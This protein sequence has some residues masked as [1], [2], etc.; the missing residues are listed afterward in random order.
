MVGPATSAGPGESRQSPCP[1]A[2]RRGNAAESSAELHQ[3]RGATCK[4]CHP[5]RGLGR[6]RCLRNKRWL[7]IRRECQCVLLDSCPTLL[8]ETSGENYSILMTGTRHQS[9]RKTPQAVLQSPTPLQQQ[10]I[11][12]LTL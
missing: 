7:P 11:E 3:R 2:A 1:C 8:E 5:S 10:H 4:P 12:D 6:A 9:K